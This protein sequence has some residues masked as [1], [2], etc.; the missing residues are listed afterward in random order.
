VI[1]VWAGLAVTYYSKFP[2]GFLISAFAFAA[3]VA[4]RLLPGARAASAPGPRRDAPPVGLATGH[5]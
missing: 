5:G 2:V 4:V 1:F 3:Y